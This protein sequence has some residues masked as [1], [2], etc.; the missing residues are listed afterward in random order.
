MVPVV[1]GAGWRV[2]DRVRALGEAVIDVSGLPLAG[3]TGARL[4]L[5]LVIFP[6]MHGKHS[7]WVSLG[8]L[9]WHRFWC[10]S[11]VERAISHSG[12]WSASRIYNPPLLMPLAYRMPSLVM[13]HSLEVK[14]AENPSFVIDGIER[15]FVLSVLRWNCSVLVNR[16]G[17][18]GVDMTVEPRPF[19]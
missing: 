18:L 2:C 14:V 1:G 10:S 3:L 6:W 8:M 4:C 13:R 7:G 11:R 17:P 19:A 15:R 9:R 16:S 5:C 12:A